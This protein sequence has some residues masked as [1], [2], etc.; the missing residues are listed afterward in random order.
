MPIKFTSKFNPSN[1]ANNINQ[2]GR[3][4]L[5]TA[6]QDEKAIMDIRTGSGRDIDGAGFQE[7]SESYGQ[8][9]EEKTGNRNVD[10]LDTGA[11]LQAIV[12]NEYQSE[13]KVEARVEF[14]MIDMAQRAIYNMKLRK[15]FGF[16]MDQF[17]RIKSKVKQSIRG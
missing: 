17:D 2:S 4:T 13:N 15:F 1:I 7:Y 10:L 6:V 8:Q 5:L 11:M 12:I 14:S 3:I 16:S 9:V